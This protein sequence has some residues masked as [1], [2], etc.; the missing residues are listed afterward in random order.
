MV[1]PRPVLL[2]SFTGMRRLPVRPAEHRPP[3]FDDKFDADTLFYDAFHDSDG[4]VVLLGPPFLNLEP[5]VRAMQVTA[6]PSGSACRFELRNWN[7]HG[8]VLVQAPPGTTGLDLSL[9]I[10]AVSVAISPGE[11]D[12]FAGRRVMFTLS[13]NN[14]LA[15]IKDW[16]RFARDVHGADA[17]LIYDNGSTAYRPEALRD[18]IAGVDGIAVARVVS[19][20]FRYGPQ[21]L[22]ATRFWDSDFCQLGVMEHA[23]RRFLTRAAGAQ[24]ADIDEMLLTRTGRSVFEAAASDPF[25]VARYDGR[26]VSAPAMGTRR[27]RQPTHRDH[28]FTL[29]KKPVR[30]YGILTADAHACPPKWTVVPARIPDR[31]QWSVH[32]FGRWLPGRR[33]SSDFS[34]RHFM[35][36]TDNWK[37]QRSGSEGTDPAQT[38]EPDGDLAS[39]FEAV[40]WSR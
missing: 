39:H 17:A 35:A 37:Y 30:R 12:V 3:D 7:R 32:A 33:K 23:R 24:N 6:L 14:R 25:G 19:W 20:P 29:K 2:S 13:R 1:V 40:D 5:A 9:P 15:W 21:G 26:W 11:T 36:I 31:V 4:R 38:F 22:D 10:G 34:Y 28:R 18:A 8:Q 27:Q 16:L